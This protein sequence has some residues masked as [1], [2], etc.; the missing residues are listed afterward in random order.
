MNK[1]ISSATLLLLSTLA[2]PSLAD[3]EQGV[4]L[5]LD[6]NTS[7]SGTA[8]AEYE[9]SNVEDEADIDDLEQEGWRDSP[10]EFKQAEESSD[11]GDAELTAEQ[12]G[13]LSAF[14]EN[15]ES[16]TKDEHVE[17]GKGLGLKLMKAW[18]EETLIAKIQEKLNGNDQATD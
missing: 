13:L 8:T 18:K 7:L 15:P 3:V 5:G 1:S 16:L 14:Q 12:Q 4:Y 2:M 11:E 10:A 6:M 9:R 17:L